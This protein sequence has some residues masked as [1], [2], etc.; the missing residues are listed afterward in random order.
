MT[1]TETKLRELQAEAGEEVPNSDSSYM[2]YRDGK[3]AGYCMALEDLAMD[4]QSACALLHTLARTKLDAGSSPRD[5]SLESLEVRTITSILTGLL[6]R[7]P[8]DHEIQTARAF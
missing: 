8:E 6:G 1:T 2:H 4:P 3:V 7:A 5:V